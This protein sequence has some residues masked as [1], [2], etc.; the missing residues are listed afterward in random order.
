MEYPSSVTLEETWNVT[1]PESGQEL[2]QAICPICAKTVNDATELE[3]GDE[4]VFCDSECQCWPHQCY[5]CLPKPEKLRLE[6]ITKE[7][8]D[9]NKKSKAE[10]A[11]EKATE[12]F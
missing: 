2:E 6:P 11:M 1:A 12:S 10:R 4:A 5:A 9:K 8:K 7:A 3:E